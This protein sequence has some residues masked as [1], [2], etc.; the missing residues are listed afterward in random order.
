MAVPAKNAATSAPTLTPLGNAVAGAVGAAFANAVVYPLDLQGDEI[1]S[2]SITEDRPTPYKGTVDAFARIL[3]EE[4]PAGLYRGLPAVLTQTVVSNFC[5][6]F[7]YDIVRKSYARAFPRTPA[8][9][10]T[11]LF[12]GALAGAL[13][14]LMTTPISVISTRY[15]VVSHIPFSQQASTQTP[16]PPFHHIL[17]D[18]V[19]TSGI[20]ALW[21]GYSASVV[22]TVNPAITYGLFERVKRAWAR[23][24]SV[25]EVFW[26]GAATKACA[27]V[28]TYPYIMA[29]V[30]M[31]MNAV[32]R[33]SKSGGD[34]ATVEI[35]DDI[36]I[37]EA[38][39]GRQRK[40]TGPVDVLIKV[41]R[42]E[43][44]PGWYRGMDAQ[45]LKAVLCQGILFV[46]KDFFAWIVTT[47]IYG[48]SKRCALFVTVFF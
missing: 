29:K 16:P 9:T 43:G 14:R 27:T 44:V 26:L 1:E 31:Q 19:N 6:F 37:T 25:A 3:R 32:A 46:T 34:S 11:E 42:S 45:L 36:P 40:Y 4:G 20:L 8:T 47:A 17:R 23:A 18:L 30:R 15:A 39:D 24:M 7:W 5:Y 13:S 33:R 35:E 28:V 12:L 22:L 2:G 10:A 41:S 48:L 21:G 38:D